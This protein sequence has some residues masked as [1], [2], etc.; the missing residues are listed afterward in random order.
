[1]A[2]KMAP[3]SPLLQTFRKG[4]G[5]I[6]KTTNPKSGKEY[7]LE[8]AEDSNTD[9]V[10]QELGSVPEPFRSI[11]VTKDT[12]PFA[13]GISD[14]DKTARK[15]AYKKA[16]PPQNQLAELQAKMKRSKKKKNG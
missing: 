4:E 1:M 8:V 14:A 6:V 16:N 10:A 5:K 9:R 12:D 15:D 11:T 13:A 2:Y 3:K 7:D